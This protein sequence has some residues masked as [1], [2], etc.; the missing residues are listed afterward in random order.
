[1]DPRGIMLDH[2]N[3]KFYNRRPN[4]PCLVLAYRFHILAFLELAQLTPKHSS[5]C[6]PLSTK[7]KFVNR[8]GSQNYLTN[9]Q[10][11]QH[12]LGY[13]LTSMKMKLFKLV[14]VISTRYIEMSQAR[15]AESDR[16]FNGLSRWTS[17]EALFIAFRSSEFAGTTRTCGPIHW[18]VKVSMKR[19]VE[20]FSFLQH[21][22]RSKE[23]TL[24][25]QKW[26]VRHKEETLESKMKTN[27]KSPLSITISEYIILYKS[28]CLRVCVCVCVC[29]RHCPSWC[30]H[31]EEG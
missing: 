17:L 13:V 12:Y 5:S 19:E 16:N 27:L 10:G 14:T 15:K 1:M 4:W 11:S 2:L 7:P 8:L 31:D 22:R 18:R 24:D 6:C 29:V 3:Q 21:G 25:F 9:T 28:V 26:Y 30:C 20:R 23:N